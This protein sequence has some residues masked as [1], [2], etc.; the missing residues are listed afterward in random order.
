MD[1]NDAAIRVKAAN[2]A[3][4]NIIGVE[5]QVPRLGIRPRDGN[6]GTVLS[7]GSSPMTD[8]IAATALVIEHPIHK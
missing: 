4:V 7:G 1:D 3:Y 6:T 5:Y 8:N 2:D